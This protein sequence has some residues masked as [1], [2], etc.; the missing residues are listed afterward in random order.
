[1]NLKRCLVVVLLSFLP[2][3][4]ISAQSASA[5]RNS[6]RGAQAKIRTITAFIRLKRQ[7]Y[8]SQVA[9]ALRLLKAAKAEF[10][11]AGYEV[12]TIRITTQPFPEYTKRLTPEE[13]VAF[14][15]EYDR[16]AQQEGF[17]PEIGP[18]MS[19]DS[20]DAR[21]ADLLGQIIAATETINA[22]HCGGG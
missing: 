17:A 10:T 4:T 12:E 13:A 22:F 19:K 2:L 8:R 15:R 3:P 18:A 7:T 9:E 21:Q 6:Q 1:M 20:D 16:L 14:F 11:K 5:Q